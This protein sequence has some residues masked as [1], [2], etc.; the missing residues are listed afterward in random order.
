MVTQKTFQR[1]KSGKVKT[2]ETINNT[3]SISECSKLGYEF[4][5]R[6]KLEIK[7]IYWEL[8]KRLRFDYTEMDL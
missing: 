7:V 8:C 4:N 2:N 5:K 1:T 3:L 6:L